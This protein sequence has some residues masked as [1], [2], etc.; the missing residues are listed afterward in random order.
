[1]NMTLKNKTKLCKFNLSEL[2]IEYC[3]S[4]QIDILTIEI[5]IYQDMI[6]FNNEK[7]YQ[8]DIICHK[9]IKKLLFS[10][11]KYKIQLGLNLL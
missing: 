10:K 8:H 1:M 4:E 5:E 3:K 2:F 11:N 7:L 6:Y 9:L